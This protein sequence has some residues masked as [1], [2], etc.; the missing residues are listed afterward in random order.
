M[1]KNYACKFGEIDI[2]M[3]DKNCLVFVEVRYRSTNF[4]AGAAYSVNI[5]K[6]VSI[7]RCA[8]L[9]VS[10]HSAGIE[11]SLRFDVVGL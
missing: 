4:C 3:T 8:L 11:Y 9:Y 2:I 6:Q 1:Q 5:K 7:I 10:L